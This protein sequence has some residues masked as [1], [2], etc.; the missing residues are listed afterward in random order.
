MKL[1]DCGFNG[2]LNISHGRRFRDAIEERLV[3][4]GHGRI[5]Y[6]DKYKDY[7]AIRRAVILRSGLTVIK[8]GAMTES[9]AEL[10]INI[11]NQILPRKGV[12][13]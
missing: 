5:M 11:L 6:P 1:P 4:Y 8:N 9:E 12:K 7:L 10:L 13:K 3:D 2:L